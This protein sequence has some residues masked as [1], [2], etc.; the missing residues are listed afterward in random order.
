MSEGFDITVVPSEGHFLVFIEAT[1][2]D[3]AQ[4]AQESFTRSGHPDF[5]HIIV[6][7]RGSQITRERTI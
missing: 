6:V 3:E 7:P 5:V 1:F 4:R 2:P